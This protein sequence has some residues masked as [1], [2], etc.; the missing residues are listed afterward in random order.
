MSIRTVRIDPAGANWSKPA[1]RRTYQAAWC[2]TLNR[3]C[4]GTHFVISTIPHQHRYSVKVHVDMLES[5]I[6]APKFEHPAP[7]KLAPGAD[8]ATKR[9]HAGGAHAIIPVRGATQRRQRLGVGLTQP[10]RWRS[11]AIIRRRCR[12]IR[13]TL[14]APWLI[15]CLRIGA[16]TSR[17]RFIF[18]GPLRSGTSRPRPYSSSHDLRRPCHWPRLPPA[19]L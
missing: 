1:A 14:L 13:A 2:C 12:Q 19:P 4:P 16:G 6:R 17:P 15:E 5:T 3:I 11:S 18:S 9:I 8:K 7:V 10:K